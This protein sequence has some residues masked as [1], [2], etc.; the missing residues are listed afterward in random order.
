M[1]YCF[2]GNELV[3]ISTGACFIVSVILNVFLGYKVCAFKNDGH[4]EVEMVNIVHEDKNEDEMH[5]NIV[6]EIRESPDRMYGSSSLPMWVR[7]SYK[8]R[9]RSG[10]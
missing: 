9:A 7:E 6:M 1:D 10:I 4:K 3:F 5:Q 8:K 2:I